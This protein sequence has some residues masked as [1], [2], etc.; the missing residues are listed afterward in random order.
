MCVIHTFGK[1][2]CGLFNS[3]YMGDS[4]YRGRSSKINTNELNVQIYKQEKDYVPV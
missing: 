1:G 3:L 4:K 2:Y